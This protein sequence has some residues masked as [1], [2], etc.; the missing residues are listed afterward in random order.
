MKATKPPRET[1]S[2]L[3]YRDAEETPTTTAPELKALAGAAL[4]LL[5]R[6]GEAT[7][8]GGNAGD[9]TWAVTAAAG[10]ATLSIR[11]SGP[12][13]PTTIPAAMAHPSVIPYDRPWVGAYR[14]I[15]AAPLVVLD[16]AWRPREP[17]RI[18]NFSRGNWEADLAQLAQ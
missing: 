5:S 2:S 9:T 16:L 18:M 10:D 17:L 15:V 1:L 6:H 14:L 7:E 12:D 8:G 3:N 11:S 13:L 4:G